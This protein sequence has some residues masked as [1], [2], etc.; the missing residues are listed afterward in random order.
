M[1]LF[2]LHS[3]LASIYAMYMVCMCV[4]IYWFVFL[5]LP[6]T[7]FGQTIRYACKMYWR[8]YIF[9]MTMYYLPFIL[10][11]K[12]FLT[13]NN[14]LF[15]NFSQSTTLE[16]S[17]QNHRLNDR[18]AETNRYLCSATHQLSW[19]MHLDSVIISV[20]QCINAP[21]TV[22]GTWE[23]KWFVHRCKKGQF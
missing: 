17:Q 3:W 9:G 21:S 6:C 7:R 5:R 23:M 22:E 11:Y 4:C 19:M 2:S 1:F 16:T 8:E 18:C 14:W 20:L 13:F 12:C 10:S 15:P